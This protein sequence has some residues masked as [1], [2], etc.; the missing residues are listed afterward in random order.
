[1]KRIIQVLFLLAALVPG[2]RAVDS[3]VVFNEL[4]YHPVTNEAASEWVELHN[5]MAIDIDLSAWE[6]TGDIG[7]TFAEGTI[8]PGGGFLVIASDPVA[9]GA[10]TGITNLAGPFTGRL[11]NG[12]AAEGT[13]LGGIAHHLSRL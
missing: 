12:Q 10:G 8:I 3:V 13:G 9:L 2:A 11:N 1:M 4:H 5:Q 6:I 7:Y